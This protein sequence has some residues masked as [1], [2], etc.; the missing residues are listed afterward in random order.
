[1]RKN[2]AWRT[3]PG[4]GGTDALVPPVHAAKNPQ[5]SAMQQLQEDQTLEAVPLGGANRL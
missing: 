2:E 3:F 5:Q 4:R 1:M